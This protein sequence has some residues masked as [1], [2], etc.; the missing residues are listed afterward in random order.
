MK[1]VIALTFL[2]ASF[3]SFASQYVSESFSKMFYASSEAELVAAVEA[4]IPA[5]QNG[6][7]KGLTQSMKFQNCAPIEARYIKVGKL[8]I[9][10]L[11]KTENGV[12][13]PSYRGQLIV[14]HTHCF[15][16]YH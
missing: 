13:V 4:A 15:V 12:L 6:E 8:L 9:K 14:T 16:T 10:K 5:I 11:Y 3:S 7:D 1:T 2:L